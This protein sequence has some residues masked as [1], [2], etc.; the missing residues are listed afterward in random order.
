MNWFGWFKKNKK[1][2]NDFWPDS[3]AK[4]NVAEKSRREV[5]PEIA[6][7]MAENIR[8]HHENMA[9]TGHGGPHKVDTTIRIP[10]RDYS[11]KM[12]VENNDGRVYTYVSP[13]QQDLGLVET[14]IAT[15]LIHEAMTPAPD[16][17]PTPPSPSQDSSPSPSSYD[18][19]P[20]YDSGSYDSGSSSY[21][22]GSSGGCDF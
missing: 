21:D 19:S 10:P 3:V 4:Q 12:R 5:P 14:I 7:K 2:P 20:S 11:S 22:S 17:S 9:K 1:T 13:I 6:Q 16:C 15:H 18:S 8:T